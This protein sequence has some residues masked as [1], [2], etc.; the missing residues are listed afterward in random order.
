MTAQ[1]VGYTSS[2]SGCRRGRRF[3]VDLS[4]FGGLLSARYATSAEISDQAVLIRGLRRVNDGI[5]PKTV[6]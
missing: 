3:L 5:S 6:R 4:I 2:S 1:T